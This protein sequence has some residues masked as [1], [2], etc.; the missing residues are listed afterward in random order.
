VAV[1]DPPLATAKPRDLTVEELAEQW[2]VS[3]NMIRKWFRKEDGVLRWGRS[4]SRPGQK[5][6]Y[7]S[8]RIPP[9]V[10]ERVRRRLSGA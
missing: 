8:L 3:P 6:A 2:N 4:E 5:R 10:A 7:L 1:E 9:E